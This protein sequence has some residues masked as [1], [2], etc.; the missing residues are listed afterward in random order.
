MQKIILLLSFVLSAAV[1]KAETTAKPKFGPATS[2]LAE[3]LFLNRSHV[4]K[5]PAPDY[6]AQSSY[7]VPQF[8]DKACSLASAVIVLNASRAN[9]VL[10]ASDE[11]ITQENLL[12][13]MKDTKWPKAVG[14][15]GQGTSLDDFGALVQTAYDRLKIKAKVRVV[16]ASEDKSYQEQLKKDLLENEKSDQNF[17]I[18]NFLQSE[19]TGDPEG[20]V[21]H[22]SPVAAY[23]A[24]S[25]KVLVNDVDRK[26]YEPYWVSLEVF[27][28][29][30]KTIDSGSKKYR[31]YIFVELLK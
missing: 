20:A 17:M 14:K 7:Y 29:G 21:G 30:M 10:G 18:A 2:P 9:L 26:W 24:K 3:R 15:S 8:N 16:H 19:Y 6:W 12:V 5:N 23:D 28:K 31:G 1:A 4:Q 27:A 22:I 25:N 11:L 13:T